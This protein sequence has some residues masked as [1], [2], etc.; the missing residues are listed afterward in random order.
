MEK[1]YELIIA[2]VLFALIILIFAKNHSND[3][4]KSYQNVQETEILRFYS[5]NYGKLY[6]L[7]CLFFFGLMYWFSTDPE[8]QTAN[9]VYLLFEILAIAFILLEGK[10]LGRPNED[11]RNPFRITGDDQRIVFKGIAKGLVVGMFVY[12]IF[13]I[14]WFYVSD[15]LVAGSLAEDPIYQATRSIPLEELAFRGFGMMI[16]VGFLYKLLDLNPSSTARTDSE[17][18][19]FRY[20]AIWGFGAIF[21]GIAFGLYHIPSWL[22]RGESITF[23]IW[24]PIIYL[25]ILGV[26]LGFLQYKYGLSIVILIHLLNNFRIEGSLVCIAL[27]V[28]FY[29]LSEVSTRN[30]MLEI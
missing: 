24:I 21:T 25:C 10:F 11:E 3:I 4:V 12:F 23:S 26:I 20:R 28:V 19:L 30:R 6:Y 16:I 2:S 15:L 22:A 8:I 18:F 7:F 5:N 1:I 29:I 9:Y 13:D 27:I 17:G 14:I